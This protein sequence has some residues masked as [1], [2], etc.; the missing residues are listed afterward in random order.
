MKSPLSPVTS[1]KVL[2]KKTE[3]AYYF[4]ENI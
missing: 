3:N 4:D 1:S 2:M